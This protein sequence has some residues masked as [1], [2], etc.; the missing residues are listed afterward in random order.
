VSGKERGLAALHVALRPAFALCLFLSQFTSSRTSFFTA[1]RY[2]LGSGVA[3]IAAGMLLWATASIHFRE[4]QR[5]DRVA[6]SGPFR[7]IRHP[8]YASI[9]VVSVGLGLVFFA[10][11]WFLVL[12]VFFPFWYWECRSEEEE[13]EQRYGRAYAVYRERTKMF[14]PGLL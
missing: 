5:S 6:T 12:V 2:V 7:T 14:I 8:I 9:Y 10:W 1:D 13:M 3:L 4:A 11:A